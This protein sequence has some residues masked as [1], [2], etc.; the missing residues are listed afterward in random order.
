MEITVGYKELL[1]ARFIPTTPGSETIH[2]TIDVLRLFNSVPEAMHRFYVQL[3]MIAAIV[4]LIIDSFK[5]FCFYL[6]PFFLSIPS[7]S[8]LLLCFA[9]L[10]IKKKHWAKYLNVV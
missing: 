9:C 8:G 1:R 10:E 4:S 3:T 2:R 5:Y 7:L 6:Q